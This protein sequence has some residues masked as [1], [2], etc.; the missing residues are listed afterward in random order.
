M[1]PITQQSTR[2]LM[3]KALGRLQQ[4]LRPDQLLALLQPQQHLAADAACQLV[5]AQRHDALPVEA[6]LVLVEC[7]VEPL[8]QC[9]WS[10]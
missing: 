4:F 10:R 8:L 7:A 2:L 3:P 1:A 6:Q 5:F 9:I